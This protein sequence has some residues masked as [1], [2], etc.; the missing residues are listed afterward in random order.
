M[1]LS[2]ILK[3]L[4]SPVVTEKAVMSTGVAP[5]YVFKVLKNA[6][7]FEIKSAIELVFKAQ[8]HKVNVLNVKPQKVRVGS[9]LGT[10]KAYKKAYVT[11]AQGHSID[12]ENMSL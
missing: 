2:R 1:N 11:L 12:L 6:T 10:K 7:K 3:V 5:M 9:R 4:V 8:V